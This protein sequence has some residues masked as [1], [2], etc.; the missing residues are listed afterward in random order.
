MSSLRAFVIM[1]QCHETPSSVPGTESCLDT[2]HPPILPPLSGP[3]LMLPGCWYFGLVD[4][5]SLS[6]F[7]VVI[8]Q[9]HCKNWISK[10]WVTAPRGKIKSGSCKIL[11]TFSEINQYITLFYVCFYL[12]TLYLIHT[13]IPQY[14]QAPCGYQNPR[15]LKS[16]I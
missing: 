5:V 10:Y 14:P 2:V 1:K 6:S 11:A 16:L 3:E 4:A 7:M 13:V 15:M 8:L 12:K 9:S